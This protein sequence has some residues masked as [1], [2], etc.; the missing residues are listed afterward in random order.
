MP[1]LRP[2]TAD[3]PVSCSAPA[4]RLDGIWDFVADAGGDTRDIG[5]LSPTGKRMQQLRERQLAFAT[6][7]RVGGGDDA[8]VERRLELGVRHDTVFDGGERA[9]RRGFELSV[10]LP[11]FDGG[12]ATRASTRS[13]MFRRFQTSRDVVLIATGTLFGTLAERSKLLPGLAASALM[14]RMAVRPLQF[15]QG[16]RMAVFAGPSVRFAFADLDYV[17]EILSTANVV[18]LIGVFGLM[19]LSVMTARRPQIAPVT[20]PLLR[21]HSRATMPCATPASGAPATAPNALTRPG[22]P[23]PTPARRTPP[24][25]SAT[26]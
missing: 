12:A 8:G 2:T 24:P 15:M 23:T 21:F 17:G 10:R 7:D 14:A 18:L 5:D 16:R 1:S 6:D 19:A 4:S 20:G 22:P 3:E 13:P 11:I 26:T 9:N 25:G